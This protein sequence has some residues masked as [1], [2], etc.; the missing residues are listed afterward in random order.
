MKRKSKEHKAGPNAKRLTATVPEFQGLSL[1]DVPNFLDVSQYKTREKQSQGIAKATLHHW[2]KFRENFRYDLECPICKDV[3]IDPIVL[4]CCGKAFCLAC[5]DNVKRCPCCRGFVKKNSETW[6]ASPLLSGFIEFFFGENV[7]KEREIRTKQRQEVV[8]RRN[9]GKKYFESKRF[10]V[11]KSLLVFALRKACTETPWACCNLDH[12]KQELEKLLQTGSANLEHMEQEQVGENEM[13]LLTNCCLDEDFQ[14]RGKTV[15]YMG[16][17][18][19]HPIIAENGEITL[20]TMQP[21]VIASTLQQMFVH[22]VGAQTW[23]NFFKANGAPQSVVEDAY[24]NPEVD[25]SLS[26]AYDRAASIAML[27]PES[28]LQSFHTMHSSITTDE[29]LDVDEIDSLSSLEE[30]LD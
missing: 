16:D 22:D 19:A 9:L 1:E 12:A 3:M 28:D 14:L 26:Q 23:G 30:S 25:L 29:D 24:C 18:M 2:D 21:W 4:P 27:L 15:F 7:G 17:E 6:R 20:N 5:L 13:V 11:L 10:H 8:N